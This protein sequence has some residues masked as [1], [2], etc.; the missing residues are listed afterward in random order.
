MYKIQ[1][2][3]KEY[4]QDKSARKL[5]EETWV[6]CGTIYSIINTDENKKYRK[7]TL[8]VLYKFFDLQI[9]DFYQEKI[10]VY[11]KY[12]NALWLLFKSRRESLK[13]SKHYVAKK[14][15]WTERHLTRIE[16]GDTTYRMNSYYLKELIKLYNFNK[17]EVDKI[18]SYI[19]TLSDI[20]NL[21]KK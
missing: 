3:L 15:K 16:K 12:N 18:I 5:R 21:A 8:D 1:E 2:K 14:I 17:E 7:Q 10:K 11:A 9:D 4:L 6:W 19:L 13:L 20:I